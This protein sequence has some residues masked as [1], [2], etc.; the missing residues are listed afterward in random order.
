M[1]RAA[2]YLRV[3]SQ[4]QPNSLETQAAEIADYA[5]HN[6]F[7]VVRTYEDRA[8]SG[9]RLKGRTALQGLLADVI[10]GGCDFEAVLVQ[11]I[12]RWGR[13]QDTDEAAHY[14]YLCREA[15]IEVRYCNEPFDN[16]PGRSGDIFKAVKRLLAAEFSR[17][18][19]AKTRTAQRRHAAAGFK[20]GG[21]AGY[22]LRRALIDHRGEV[23][24]ILEAGQQRLLR[25]DRVIL[26]PGPA[27]EVEVVRRIY[28]MFIDEDLAMNV[29]AEHL[30]AE[31]TLAA[32]GRP[33]G[34]WSIAQVLSNPKYAGDYVFGRRPRTLDGQRVNSPPEALIRTLDAFEPIVPRSWLIAAA[35]KRRRRLLF[36]PR[37]EIWIRLHQFATERGGLRRSEVASCV[38]L[39]SPRTCTNHFG[40][41]ARLEA[42]LGLCPALLPGYID[43]GSV[44][45]QGHAHSNSTVPMPSSSYTA[46]VASRRVAHGDLS[47]VALAVHAAQDLQTE[48]PI[49]FDD[50]T[51]AV[52]DLDLRGS[53]DD[54]LQRLPQ[55]DPEG[56]EVET[57]DTPRS[58]GRP[59]LG[60][61][62]REVTLLPKHWAWLQRQPGGASGALRRL[63]EQ[64]ERDNAQ[65]D[66][67]RDAQ[68]ASYKVMHALAGHRKGYEAAL[69]ALYAGDATAYAKAIRGWPD[70]VVHYLTRLSKQAWP[71][72]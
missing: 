30:N 46:F 48:M 65:A 18:L 63:V 3:S 26:V 56:S 21:V 15:G 27:E 35:Q 53:A 64:A 12:S 62:A 68:T 29:I 71:G 60:V 17:E 42:R 41:W 49:V 10:A 20:M 59:K 57:P 58:R 31:G 25:D 28:R 11:D 23:T 40:P 33:W 67:Q 2:Q 6:D 43:G 66:A 55:A 44:L 50:A 5:A 24:A 37:E 70:D 54:V 19:S 9:L 45:S 39:P 22:G 36:L 13:F 32:R 16:V 1:R 69:R 51:G 61:M 52:I 4:H 7:E 8:R 38:W 47:T 34:G 14:E 72:A